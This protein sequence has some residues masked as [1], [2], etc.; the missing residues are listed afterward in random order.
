MYLFVTEIF[1][2]TVNLRGQKVR[3]PTLSNRYKQR[4]V[5]VNVKRSTSVMEWGCLYRNGG[6]DSLYFLPPPQ[7]HH[8][9]GRFMAMLKE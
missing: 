8:E 9:W 4:Y 5:V 2:F 1:M 3:R 6:R 7:D